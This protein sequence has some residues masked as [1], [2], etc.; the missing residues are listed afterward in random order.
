MDWL[1]GVSARVAAVAARV[2][3]GMVLLDTNDEKVS[4]F[5]AAGLT[6]RTVR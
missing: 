3:K 1:T 2:N 5:D 4:A 6:G